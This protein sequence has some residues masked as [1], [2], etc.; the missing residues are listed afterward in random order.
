L[1]AHPEHGLGAMAQ[2]RCQILVTH[3]QTHNAD[4]RHRAPREA[5]AQP[6]VSGRCAPTAFWPREGPRVRISF[7]PP[8]SLSHRC[9]PRLPAQRPGF[10]G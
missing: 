3:N 9:L 4:S 6:R 7:P 10:R 1:P 8:A 2:T 5:A